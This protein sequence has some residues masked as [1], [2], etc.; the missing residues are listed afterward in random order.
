MK[1][2]T[3][4]SKKY[5]PKMGHEIEFYN[6]KDKETGV[7]EF[8]GANAVSVYPHTVTYLDRDG[9]PLRTAAWVENKDIIREIKGV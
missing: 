1:M 9:N 8:I 4:Q 5:K 2:A 7:V 3:R 6:G